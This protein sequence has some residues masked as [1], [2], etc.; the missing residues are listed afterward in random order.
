MGYS[1]TEYMNRHGYYPSGGS[2]AARPRPQTAPRATS[3]QAFAIT[4]MTASF[5]AWADDLE[6]AVE[7]AI[8]P[9]AQAGAEVLYSAVLRNVS[10]LGPVTGKLEA[11]IYQAFV[12]KESGPTHAKY[13][14]SWNHRVAPHGHLLEDGFIQKYKVY[15]GKDG[16]WYTNKKAPLPTPVQR[17]AR[18][19]VRSAA[20]YIPQA[21]AAM[22]ERF[23]E[24]ISDAI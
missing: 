23:F 18:A 17:P 16:K 10:R 12:K 8:R 15:V 22:Q 19:F 1:S 11:S 7:A 13:D 3:G 14:I 24:E 9:A 6:G 4:D 21:E 2:G 20:A 5:D